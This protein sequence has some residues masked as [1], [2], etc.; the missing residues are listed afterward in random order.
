MPH[1]VTIP[2]PALAGQ[3]YFADQPVPTALAKPCQPDNLASSDRSQTARRGVK[4]GHDC[5]PP[6]ALRTKVSSK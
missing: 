3:Q 2:R 4:T 5:W 1:T 6:S